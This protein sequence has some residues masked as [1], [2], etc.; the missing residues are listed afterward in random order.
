LLPRWAS[1]ILITGMRTGAVYRYKLSADGKS[2][3]GPPTEYF[4]ADDRYRDVAVSPDG[5][6]YL[7]TDSFG[8]TADAAGRRTDRLANPGAIVEFSYKD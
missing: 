2:V 5:R 1:S 6:I 4:K 3:D 8:A 7:V